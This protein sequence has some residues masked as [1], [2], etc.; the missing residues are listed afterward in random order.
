M[1]ENIKGFL[2]M[3]VKRITSNQCIPRN[4]VW[5][6][7]S[8]NQGARGAQTPT[9]SIK[10]SQSSLYNNISFKPSSQN[11]TMNLLSSAK[12]T[13]SRTRLEHKR[14]RKI[15]R[16]PTIHVDRQHIFV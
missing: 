8:I 2:I 14:K 13:H 9:S 12:G 15:I 4:Q 6:W 16:K 11:S 10:I 5:F 7:N 3:P 1:L